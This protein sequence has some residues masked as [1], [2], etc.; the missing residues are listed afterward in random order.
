MGICNFGDSSMTPGGVGGGVCGGAATSGYKNE[1]EMFMH[2]PPKYEEVVKQ[3]RR[4]AQPTSGNGGHDDLL[5]HQT[6]LLTAANNNGYELQGAIRRLDSVDEAASGLIG[7]DVSSSST[8][9]PPYISLP[10]IAKSTSA[11]PPAGS[12]AS[13]IV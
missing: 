11:S 7:A 3:I 1:D 5:R 13:H 2:G 9:A 8:Q 6:S 10:M 12:N 4:E